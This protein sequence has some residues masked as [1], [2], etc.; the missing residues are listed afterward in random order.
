MVHDDQPIDPGRAAVALLL[1]R[2][3]AGL[4]FTYHGAQ[5]LFGAFGGP[6]VAGFGQ[7]AHLAAVT[8]LL[9]GLAEF[10]GGVAVLTGALAR[11][12]AAC[13]VVVML[14]AIVLVHAPHG[15]DGTKGGLE[16]PLTQT[17]IALAILTT[18]PGPYSVTAL[19]RSPIRGT[20]PLTPAR[21]GRT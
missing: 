15:F 5:I 18:G 10:C 20:T 17:L 8:A 9:V 3:A 19:I 7:H 1:I 21:P 14:G 11:L 13:I 4:A 6:G 16:Y 2:I 12:G